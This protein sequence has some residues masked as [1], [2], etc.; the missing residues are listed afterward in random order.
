MDIY[1]TYKSNKGIIHK[2]ASKYARTKEDMEDMEQ[3]GFIALMNALNHYDTTQDASFCT[4]AYTVIER[5]IQRYINKNTGLS[6][7]IQKRA[8]IAAYKKYINEYY[9]RFGKRPSYEDTANRLHMDIEQVKA[10]DVY[11][12]Q[13]DLVSIDK[14]KYD[15]AEDTIGELLPD[16]INIENEVIEA[17]YKQN[18]YNQLHRDIDTLEEPQR[19]VIK[20]RY[21]DDCVKSIT[22]VCEELG[23]SE[24]E[25]KQLHRKAISALRKKAD[26]DIV[27]EYA[28]EYI[29]NAG[30]R[31]YNFHTTWTSSTEYVALKR[32][33]HISH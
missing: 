22:A 33:E 13:L 24:H 4:Y 17:D 10:L 26:N 11:T 1:D 8:D 31:N 25:V 7:G 30:L 27:G 20:A 28:D 6:G 14:Q 32:L 19:A 9:L 21:T 15:N 16:N 3:E 2:I 23:Q 5:H 29:Y 18:I 12:Y